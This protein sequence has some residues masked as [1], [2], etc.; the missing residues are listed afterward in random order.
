MS[1]NKEEI[2]LIIKD[3]IYSGYYWPREQLVE[4]KLAEEMKVSRTVIREVLR[5]LALKSIV[6]ILPHKGAFVA[7]LSYKDM[8][9]TLALEAILESSAAYLSTPRLTNAQI[10][11]LHGLLEH[12]KKLDHQDI[13]SW[14]DYNW[15]FHKIIITACGNQKMI[16]LIRDNV[17]FVKYWFVK[18]TLPEE[19]IERT[20]AH[21][22]ILDAIERRNAA[23]VRELMENHLLFAANDLL[24]RIKCSNPTLIQSGQTNLA[25]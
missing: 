13:Q 17:R 16:S 9:E 8:I 22:N 2:G 15:Q 24:S 19:I 4:S 23:L 7:E 3:R 21:D 1:K 20:V 5:E 18:L 6:T 14:A 25:R 10:A 12:S 11:E